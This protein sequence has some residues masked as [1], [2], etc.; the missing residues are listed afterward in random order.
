MFLLFQTDG[1]GG[2]ESLGIENTLW[3]GTV[4]ASGT[5]LGVVVYTGKET[6]AV[7]NTSQPKSKVRTLTVLYRE[8]TMGWNSGSLRNGTRRGCIYW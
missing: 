8:H 3:A 4:V 6:R 1:Q 5:A 7:M 2:E